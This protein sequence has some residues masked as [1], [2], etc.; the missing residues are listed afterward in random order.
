M[1]QVFLPHLIFVLKFVLLV[2]VV[3]ECE[4]VDGCGVDG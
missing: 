4:C 1:C 2:C 3:C